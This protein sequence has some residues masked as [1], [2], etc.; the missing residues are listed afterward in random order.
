MAINSIILCVDKLC[1][2]LKKRAMKIIN[3]EEKEVIPLTDEENKSYEEQEICHICNE[4][5]C[6]EEHGEN[7]KNR[8]K[9]KDHCHY[10][11]KFRGA[12]HSICNLR[13][14]VPENIPIVIHNASYD[15]HF[16]I[17][18]LAEEFKGELNCIGEN[19]EK[20]ITFSVPVKKECG[21]GKTISCK[22]RFIDSFRFMSASLSE[23]VDNMSGIFNTIECKSFIEKIKINSEC[24]FVGLKNNR[25]IYRCRECKKECERPT[26]ELIRKFPRSYQFCNGEV[27]KFILL[28]RKGVYPYEDMDNR[29]NFDETTIPPKEAFYS[30]LNLEGVSD[31]DYAHAQKVLEVFGI[32]NRGEYHDL[33]M[34]SDTLLLAD[35]FE[36]MCLEIYELDPVYFLSTPGLAWQGCLKKAGVKLELLT[37][38][39]MLL[40][41]KRGLGVICQA[42]HRYARANNK[43]MKNYDKS[44]ESSYIECLDAKIYT[45]EQCLK[46]LR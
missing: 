36:N 3:Y 6:T 32:K 40:W 5:F 18:Q 8:R 29:E 39:H 13:Y 4:K 24:C 37:D 30:K 33:Y 22:L 16:I 2:K 21:D 27:N 35:V 45:D 41:L 19:M 15:T 38:Y 14:K 11:G 31:A 34:Q 23:L 10:T 42:T 46:N 9:V 28:L 1:K 26:E 25:L 7:Y 43:Y 17:N 44:L 12:A 20:Y